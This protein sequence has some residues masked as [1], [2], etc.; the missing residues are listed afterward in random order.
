MHTHGEQTYPDECCGAMYGPGDGRITHVFALS[1]TFPDGQ[2][3]RFLVGPDEY[4]RASNTRLS[5]SC[6]RRLLSHRTRITPPNRRRSI[7]STRGRI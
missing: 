5:Q 3:R 2:R 4:R 1:N 6:P 7:S